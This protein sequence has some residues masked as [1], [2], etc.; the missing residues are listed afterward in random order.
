MPVA[1]ALRG[2]AALTARPR[3][4]PAPGPALLRRIAEAIV[5]SRRRKAI[6]DL[7]R[8][9]LGNQFNGG[10]DF[11]VAYTTDTNL[12]VLSMGLDGTDF[13]EFKLQG[14]TGGPITDQMPANTSP[15]QL[16][17][18]VGLTSGPFSS[19][20]TYNYVASYSI[21]GVVGQNHISSFQLVNAMISYD[22]DGTW[23]AFSGATASLNINNLFDTNPPFV[24]SGNGTVIAPVLEN[25]L[26][27]YFQ[28]T[29]TKKF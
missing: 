20:L 18:N 15:Y 28:F 10:L 8:H 7:R 17:A 23:D 4:K 26:G 24:N 1:T 11:H 2:P 5:D 25:T 6:R 21:T 29:L 22:L 27:R 16:T 12:G 19:K 9:N 14:Y 3:S 13:T